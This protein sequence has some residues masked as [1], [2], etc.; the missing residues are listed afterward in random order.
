MLLSDKLFIELPALYYG[1]AAALVAILWWWSRR[2]TRP[3]DRLALRAISYGVLLGSFA[4]GVEHAGWVYPAWLGLVRGSTAAG[5]SIVGIAIWSGIA[6]WAA[7]LLEDAMPVA[8]RWGAVLLTLPT[9]LLA[10]LVLDKPI[11]EG[12]K[13]WERASQRFESQA[14]E[15]HANTLAG[16]KERDAIQ[17]P[18]GLFTATED[19]FVIARLPERDVSYATAPLERGGKF[20]LRTAPGSLT[21]QETLLVS[22]AAT[23]ESRGFDQG[24][25]EAT[26]FLQQDDVLIAIRFVGSSPPQEAEPAAAAASAPATAPPR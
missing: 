4:I 18:A 23:D 16:L 22:I 7:V 9:L 19:G 20:V 13:K 17:A 24:Q 6:L 14:R 11:L 25:T 1:P 2:F 5:W 15:R 8:R 3:R 21:A 12:L 26:M 10:S